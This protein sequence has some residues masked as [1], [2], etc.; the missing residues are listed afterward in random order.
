MNVKLENAILFHS[1]KHHLARIRQFVIDYQNNVN[2]QTIL[3][4]KSLGQSQF[5]LYLGALTIEQI[6][7][8]TSSFLLDNNFITRLYYKSWVEANQGYRQITLSDNST[9]TLR[10]LDQPKFVHIHPSRYAQHTTRIK[11]N[12]MKTAILLQ[13]FERELSYESIN[14]VRKLLELS[15]VSLRADLSGMEKAYGLLK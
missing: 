2:G 11:A 13:L 5:D 4:I 10:F 14:E 15:P 8:E 6:L 1:L 3:L 7:K 9:W 12:A